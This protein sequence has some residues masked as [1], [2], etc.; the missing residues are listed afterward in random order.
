LNS[1]RAQ[2]AEIAL[3]R[4]C[5]ACTLIFWSLPCRSKK[6]DRRASALPF[7]TRTGRRS[8]FELNRNPV[9]LT[10]LAQLSC[11]RALGPDVSGSP[12]WGRLATSATRRL[13]VLGAPAAL[14]LSSIHLTE[15]FLILRRYPAIVKGRSEIYSDS[16]FRAI[17]SLHPPKP[18]INV[19]EKCVTRGQQ[20]SVD[21]VIGRAADFHS[22]LNPLPGSLRQ[23]PF[24]SAGRRLPRSFRG[25]ATALLP[26]GERPSVI[27]SPFA[28]LRVNST[29]NLHLF[30]PP[31]PARPRR[32]R[33]PKSC[34]R[35]PRGGRNNEDGRC[36]ALPWRDHF[37]KWTFTSWMLAL[38][39]E[40]I[41][42]RPSL[43]KRMLA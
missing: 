15:Q 7:A 22:S 39:I 37:C 38:F 31:L 4:T 43:L 19:Q 12:S 24:C 21:P 1:A 33:P 36:L 23:D 10:W 18:P 41:S 26:W 5:S 11:Q 29:K 3:Q 34:P 2:T 32:L 28:T 16:T 6:P 17:P 9:R 8:A 40:M 20:S 27:L 42:I 13:T 35:H 25:P 30:L 14:T